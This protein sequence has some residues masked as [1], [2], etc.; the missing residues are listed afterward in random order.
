ML[1]PILF[2]FGYLLVAIGSGVII[3][4]PIRR[5]M[6]FG[7]ARH[8]DP[9]SEGDALLVLLTVIVGAAAMW[10]LVISLY[11]AGRFIAHTVD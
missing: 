4:A 2:V 6:G 3:A 9:L 10:P 1:N 7:E 11:C 8:A 5:V